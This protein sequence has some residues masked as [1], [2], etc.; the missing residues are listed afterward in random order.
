MAFSRVCHF[1]AGRK[2]DLQRD[3]GKKC[4]RGLRWS[5]EDCRR[6]HCQE[7][8]LAV[9]TQFHDTQKTMRGGERRTR[10]SREQREREREKDGI[11]RQDGKIKTGNAILH[12]DAEKFEGRTQGLQLRGRAWEEASCPSLRAAQISCF[13]HFSSPRATIE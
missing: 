1:F 2:L 9:L 5:G 10:G 3:R 11:G 8:P 12:Y 6:G 4:E 13:T 7:G